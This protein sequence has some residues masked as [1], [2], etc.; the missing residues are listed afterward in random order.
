MLAGVGALKFARSAEGI[1]TYDWWDPLSGPMVTSEAVEKYRKYRA[2][3]ENAE[4]HHPPLIGASEESIDGERGP[5]A[6]PDVCDTIGAIAID[7]HGKL[8]AAVSTGG[9]VLKFPGRV[10]DSAFPG[11]GCWTSK[12]RS[13]P[14]KSCEFACSTTGKKGSCKRRSKVK[15]TACIQRH[16]FH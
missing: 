5:A 7:S 14:P 6:L 3:I 16:Y 12:S 15:E 13:K 4:D 9:I 11:C 1:E 2:T 10:G 8:A